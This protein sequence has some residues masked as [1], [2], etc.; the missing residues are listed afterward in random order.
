[1]VASSPPGRSLVFRAT[2][3]PILRAGLIERHGKTMWEVPRVRQRI[4]VEGRVATLGSSA[5]NE[6]EGHGNTEYME[7]RK[8]KPY[9]FSVPS[10]F[11][12]FR[13]SVSKSFLG[14]DFRRRADRRKTTKKC[15]TRQKAGEHLPISSIPL[16][17][18]LT[19]LFFPHQS[20]VDF[21]RQGR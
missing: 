18:S 12:P 6:Q 13:A 3:T 21:G 5:R 19:R 8:K 10:A 14:K 1:M 9:L 2:P 7:A 16:S 4:V 15:H 11:P 17:P 20:R